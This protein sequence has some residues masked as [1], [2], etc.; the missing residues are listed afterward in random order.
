MKALNIG[1]R[2]YT[3]CGM[4]LYV[5]DYDWENNRKVYYCYLWEHREQPC[6]GPCYGLHRNDLTTLDPIGF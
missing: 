6:F 3:H 5:D 4:K 2:V 1:Q